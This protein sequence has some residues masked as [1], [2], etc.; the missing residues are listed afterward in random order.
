MLTFTDLCDITLKTLNSGIL[1]I[2]VHRRIWSICVTFYLV[3]NH[4]KWYTESSTNIICKKIVSSSSFACLSIFKISESFD[5]I[6]SNIRHL[7]NFRHLLCLRWQNCLSYLWIE[8]REW[9]ELMGKIN[10][11]LQAFRIFAI[12]NKNLI[13]IKFS[14]FFFT[15][16]QSRL[17][18]L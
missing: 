10:V 18:C 5:V 8:A 13:S 14:I 15:K 1:L 9:M 7:F 2:P 4:N 3:Y 6:S 12:R 11:L 17:Q 16:Q